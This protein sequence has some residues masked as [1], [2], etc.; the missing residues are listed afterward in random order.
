MAT[1]LL[2]NSAETILAVVKKIADTPIDD[3]VKFES[4]R[5]IAEVIREDANYSGIRVTLSGVLS[6]A[7]VRGRR[8]GN[9]LTCYPTTL[10]ADAHASDS[11]TRCQGAAAREDV[12]TL[13]RLGPLP[14][15]HAHYLRFAELQDELVGVPANRC[16]EHFSRTG[17]RRVGQNRT[18]GVELESRSFNLSAHG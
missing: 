8:G 9:S 1:R 10:S 16:I 17:V 18:L 7:V 15:G 14:R 2:E 13:R 4:A 12:S 11:N 3:G 6:R 5:A